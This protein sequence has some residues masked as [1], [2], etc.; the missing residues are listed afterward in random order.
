MHKLRI[1]FVTK[2]G[3]ANLTKDIF[4]DMWDVAEVG[5]CLIDFSSDDSDEGR[6]KKWVTRAE[7]KWE[8]AWTS[9]K[10]EYDSK[11]YGI[12]KREGGRRQNV[13]FSEVEDPGVVSSVR[14]FFGGL[15]TSCVRAPEVSE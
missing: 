2:E 12:P 14:N 8:A 4:K 3:F 9:L 13:S 7:N 1:V 15:L 10:D 6:A 11:V 5:F